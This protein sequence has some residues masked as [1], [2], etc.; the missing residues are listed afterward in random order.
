MKLVIERGEL[1]RALGHVTSVVERRTTIPILSNVLLKASE[2]GA[3]IQGHRPR[4]RGVGARRP[5][6]SRKPGAVDGAGAHAAR[7]RA[8]AARRRRGGDQARRREGAPDAHARA[9]RASRC[10]RWRRR[11]FPISPPASSTT[12]SRSPPS[13]LKRLIDKT[14]FAIST[15]ETRYYLNGIYLHAATRGK[16]P[17]LRAVATDGH[18]L[19]QAELPLP[20]G[21]RRHARH[22]PA[23]Q[24]GARAASPDRGQ[25][26]HRH[27]SA[28]RRP[29]RASRSA[30]SR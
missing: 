12:S 6:T 27:R 25:R 24:D 4:A 3:A 15:E 19:A 29:R 14:R 17:T 7:H 11:I 1:L 13:D 8:Q 26:R 10:R 5:P 22:H 28:C 30:P 20:E 9:I 2:Q 21:R 16:E 18:R 23:A